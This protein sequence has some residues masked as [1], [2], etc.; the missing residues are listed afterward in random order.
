MPDAIGGHLLKE[1][2]EEKERKKEGKLTNEMQRNFDY[3]SASQLFRYG[4]TLMLFQFSFFLSFLC[5]YSWDIRRY[6]LQV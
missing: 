2:K 5:I 4:Y 1:K 6:V 3:S